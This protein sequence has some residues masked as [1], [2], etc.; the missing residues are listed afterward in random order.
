M[1]KSLPYNQEKA[2]PVRGRGRQKRPASNG[3]KK[4]LGQNWLKSESALNEIIKAA[5]LQV[6]DLVLEVGPG[7]GV[8]TEKLLAFCPDTSK[9][10]GVPTAPHWDFQLS[11]GNEEE[12]RKGAKVIAVEKDDRLIELLKEKFAEEIKE[13][14]LTL[15]HDD[16]LKLDF[17]NFLKMDSRLPLHLKLR[18][19][20]CGNDKVR[21]YKLV[22]NIPYYITGQVIRKF[23]SEEKIQP[24]RIVLMLQKE[25]A[26]RIVATH[27]KPHKTASGHWAK[28]SLISIAV[29]AY[30]EPKYIKTVSANAF[31]PKPK[32]DSA[33]LLVQN[34]SR[35]NFYDVSEQEFFAILKKGFAQ[36]RKK[37]AG[38]LKL[39]KGELVA[40]GLSENV[41]AEELSVNNWF[42]LAKLLKKVFKKW[43]NLS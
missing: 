14:Q 38:N 22:A 12:K 10:V 13:G 33:I 21:G 11:G 39:K 4:S 36:K 18:R 35:N 43:G 9:K 41:R 17:S 15:I 29:K 2:N 25:V 3:A 8:L 34:I 1:K 7:R 20:N 26:R 5:D 24:S 30:G 28:E 27:K 32:V 31:L 37:L 40:C 42:C 19:T 6:N 16:I 23:L